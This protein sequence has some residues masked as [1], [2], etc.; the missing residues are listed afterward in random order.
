MADQAVSLDL[1]NI[2]TDVA[3][4]VSREWVDQNSACPFQKTG[5]RVHFATPRSLDEHQALRASIEA[6]IGTGN[7][8]ITIVPYARYQQLVSEQGNN[9]SN[10]LDGVKGPSQDVGKIIAEAGAKQDADAELVHR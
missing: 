6:T 7:F 4:L 1:S 3:G 10:S 8:G 2:N 9:F 5:D